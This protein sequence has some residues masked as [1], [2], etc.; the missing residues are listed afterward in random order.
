VAAL[1]PL[2][3]CGHPRGEPGSA[4]ALESGNAVAPVRFDLKFL[5]PDAG[6]RPATCFR[7]SD[8]VGAS[9]ATGAWR[10]KGGYRAVPRRI[11]AALPGGALAGGNCGALCVVPET[12]RGTR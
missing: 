4:H 12:G 1:V 7:R 8:P 9:A 10:L 2:D 6:P 5:Q 11:P 3:L